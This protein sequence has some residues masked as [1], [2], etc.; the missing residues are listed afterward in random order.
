VGLRLAVLCWG[1][2]ASVAWS[3]DWDWNSELRQAPPVPGQP[4]PTYVSGEAIQGQT[5]AQVVIS[6]NAQLRRQGLVIQGDTIHHDNNTQAVRVQGDVRVVN[7]GDRYQGTQLDLNLDTQQGVFDSPEFELTNGGLG[8][9]KALTFLGG[10]SSRAD[11]VQYSTCP[12]PNSG[13]WKPDWMLRASSV[14]FDRTNDVGTAWGAVVSFKGVPLLATPWLSF[15]LTD[16]RKSGFLPLGVNLSDTS[17]LELVLPY[18]LN[19]APNYDATIYPTYL[20]KRGLNLGAEFRYLQPGWGGQLRADTMPSDQLRPTVSRYGWAWQH[21]QA[22][23]WGDQ[24]WGLSVNANQ[25]SDDNYWRDFPRTITSLTA[26]Q[27]PTNVVATTAGADWSL[28]VGSYQWQTLQ[29][30]DTIVAAY[31]RAPQLSVNW[32]P[33]AVQNWGLDLNTEL[34]RFEVDRAG[35]QNGWRWLGSAGL[36]HRFDNAGAY[37]TPALRVQSRRYQ[38]DDE[39][40]GAGPWQGMREANVTVPTASL[41]S[42]LVF[43]RDLQSGGLQTL[44]PRLLLAYTPTKVQQ[45]LPLYDAAAKDFNFSSVFSPYEYSGSDRVADNRSVTWGLSSRWLGADGAEWLSLSAAQKTRFSDLHV[46]LDDS[47][48]LLKGSSDWLLGGNWRYNKK[49][50]AAAFGQYDRDMGRLRRSTASLRYQGGAFRNAQVA[51]SFQRDASELLDLTWQWP[52]NDLWGDRGQL[53]AGG[54]NL[55][56]PRWYSVGR[57]NYSMPER[58]VVD[59]IAGLEYDNG[60]WLGRVAIERQ[61]NSTSSASHRLFFQLEFSGFGRLGSSPLQTLQDNVPYYQVLRQEYVAPNRFE[62]YD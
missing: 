1:L 3:Q 12:R 11:E 55:G 40:S 32:R 17:G 42:G 50:S 46:T 48:P 33:S 41:D 59:M 18:Y 30:P 49:W 6:G 29:Q 9:A 8:H 26:R 47:G 39:L 37:A 45:G 56:A 24:A 19:L 10:G 31:D 20:S 4:L 60:C 52:L 15:P 28:S 58:K 25:V 51:Y 27:L 16:A 5:D 2:S 22:L 44:E 35:A 34:T 36:S 38:L 43:E 61:Q 23:R 53:S 21:Q 57:L 7:Q 62:N 14:E 13:A 54:G